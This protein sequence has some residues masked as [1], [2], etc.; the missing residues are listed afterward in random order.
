MAE[1]AGKIFTSWFESGNLTGDRVSPVPLSLHFSFTWM[2][3][4][5]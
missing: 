3:D 2:E 5:I 1:I 4:E